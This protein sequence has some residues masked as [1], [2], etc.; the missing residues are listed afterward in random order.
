MMRGPDSQA[1]VCTRVNSCLQ[2]PVLLRYLYLPPEIKRCHESFFSVFLHSVTGR[3]PRRAFLTDFCRAKT[4]KRYRT[5]KGVVG[6][7]AQGSLL[8]SLNAR[9]HRLKLPRF[10]RALVHGTL[11]TDWSHG[12]RQAFGD[13]CDCVLS[14]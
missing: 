9:R 8:I 14:Q 10:E 3:G 1:V 6:A 11:Q 5:V 12:L 2:L 13:S 4:R 7:Y